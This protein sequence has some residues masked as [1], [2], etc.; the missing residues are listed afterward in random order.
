MPSYDFVCHDCRRKVTLFFKSFADYDT[1]TP[2]CPRC[3]GTNLTRRIKRVRIARSEDAIF[4][5]LEDEAALADLDDADPRTLARMMRKMG[6][7]LGED[8]GDE[9]D[10]VVDRLEHGEDPAA[11]ESSMPELNDGGMGGGFGVGLGDGLLDA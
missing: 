1:A 8:L 7:E 10:E 3:N 11:I 4:D 5:N 2:T 6:S 9:F